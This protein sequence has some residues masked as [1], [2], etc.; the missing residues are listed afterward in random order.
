MGE[1]F[2]SFHCDVFPLFNPFALSMLLS[3]IKLLNSLVYLSSSLQTVNR[4]LRWFN[5]DHIYMRNNNDDQYWL[6][7][8]YSYNLKLL[9]N[10]GNYIVIIY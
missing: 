4:F 5:T 7:I 1:F 6:A 2:S 3:N 8:T 10:S 9:Y